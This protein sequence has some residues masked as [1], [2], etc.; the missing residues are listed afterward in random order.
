MTGVS[1]GGFAALQA[2]ARNPPALK[3]IAPIHASDDRYADDVHYFGGC[4]LAT[5]MLHWSACMAAYVGQP[6]DPAV[7]GDGWRE[8][9]RER[10]DVDGA[11]G[12]HRGSPTSAATTTG[13]RARPAS[14]TRDITC[15]VFAIGGWSTATATRCCGCSSTSARPCA[16]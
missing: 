14:T 2:A 4:V 3:G 1:W 9:W 7:V 12:R 15:P 8:R 6:P 13:A 11:V 16:G 5:D 10:L